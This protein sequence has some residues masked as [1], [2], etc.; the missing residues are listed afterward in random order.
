MFHEELRHGRKQFIQDRPTE[1]R[2]DIKIRRCIRVSRIVVRL[3]RR[4]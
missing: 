3:S 2:R 4:A 1:S